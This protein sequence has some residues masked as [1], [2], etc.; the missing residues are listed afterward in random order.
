MD[1][2]FR[3]TASALSAG[4]SSSAIVV[5]MY[6]RHVVRRDLDRQLLHGGKPRR[7]LFVLFG[8]MDVDQAVLLRA[9][10][11]NPPHLQPARFVQLAGP[12]SKWNSPSMFC[13]RQPLAT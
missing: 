3:P 13:R 6:R 12:G 10:D 11:K 2:N 1:W 7:G 5:G 4:A 9:G 8:H